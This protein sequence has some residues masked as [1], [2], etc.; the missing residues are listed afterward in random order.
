MP[1]IF[2]MTVKASKSSKAVVCDE[3]DKTGAEAVA[4]VDEAVRSL[5]SWGYMNSKVNQYHPFQ[6]KGA[7]DDP[8]FYKRPRE[9]TRP[10]KSGER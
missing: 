2:T 5:C 7:A 4:A 6:F 8:A 10:A 1:R 9:L 3:D